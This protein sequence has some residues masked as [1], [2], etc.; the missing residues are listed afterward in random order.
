MRLLTVTALL[1]AW[2]S[3]AAAAPPDSVVAATRAACKS[4]AQ[5]LC[6]MQILAHDRPG[7]R[8]CL[9]SNL[10]KVTPECLTA[11]KALQAAK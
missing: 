4:S 10:D 9:L 6:A 1:L 3:A 5:R 2:A 7:V 11:M 8:A